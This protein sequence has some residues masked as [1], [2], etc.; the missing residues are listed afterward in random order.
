[1]L[2]HDEQQESRIDA[3]DMPPC[4]HCGWPWEQCVCDRY[5]PKEDFTEE[6]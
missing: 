5:E 1:M 4:L 3:P 6:L 2:N